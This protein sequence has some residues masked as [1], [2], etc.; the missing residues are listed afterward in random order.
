MIFRISPKKDTITFKKDN[1]YLFLKLLDFTEKEIEIIRFIYSKSL[2]IN[3]E[4]ISSATQEQIKNELKSSSITIT[5]AIKK[6]VNNNLCEIK[7]GRRTSLYK[8]VEIR[9]IKY[10]K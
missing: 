9:K 5:K 1:F 4:L 6:L 7:K 10:I 2:Q 3:K 8:L